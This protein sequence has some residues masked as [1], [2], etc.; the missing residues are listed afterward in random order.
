MTIHPD[1]DQ[2]ERDRR[3][4]ERDRQL[5]SM[6]AYFDAHP[7]EYAKLEK[8]ARHLMLAESRRLNA[9]ANHEFVEG[10][11]EQWADPHASLRK[12]L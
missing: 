3:H 11:E 9:E 10:F 12:G 5:A 4:A 1:H 2:L 8:L 6:K 7:A